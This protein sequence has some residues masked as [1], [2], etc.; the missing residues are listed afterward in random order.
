MMLEKKPIK[1]QSEA[2]R[3]IITEGSPRLLHGL[4]YTHRGG[5]SAEPSAAGGGAG[6]G[7][8]G[9]GAVRAWPSARVLSFC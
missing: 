9:V 4:G 7:G 3:P 2:I 1:P 5:L 6:G 8:A